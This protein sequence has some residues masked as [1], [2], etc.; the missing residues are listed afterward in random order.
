M[1]IRVVLLLLLLSISTGVSNAQA[2]D[3]LEW[4][5]AQ[6]SSQ[7]LSGNDANLSEVLLMV[8]DIHASYTTVSMRSGGTRVLAR[9]VLRVGES[10]PFTWKGEKYRLH[11]DDIDYELIGMDY[12]YIRVE[13]IRKTPAPNTQEV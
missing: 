1:L 12:A 4:R 5:V 10:L 6:K 9:H 11:L 2:S 3:V 13:R 7:Y 8:G